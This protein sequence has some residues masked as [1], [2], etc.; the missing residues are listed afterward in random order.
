MKRL[1]S[2]LLIIIG[3]VAGNHVCQKQSVAAATRPAVLLVYDSQHSET[4]QDQPVA[5]MTRLLLG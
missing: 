1:F 2:C 3:L 5:D 4:A